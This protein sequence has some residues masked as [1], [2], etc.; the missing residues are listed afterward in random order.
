VYALELEDSREV[1]IQVT[2]QT[3]QGDVTLS[4]RHRCRE[5]ATELSCIDQ[6]GTGASESRTTVFSEGTYYIVAQAPADSTLGPYQLTVDSPFTTTCGPGSDYCV[7]RSTAAIC[8]PRGGTL[9]DM[10][11]ETGCNPTFGECFEN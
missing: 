8:G 2:P 9:N 6:G 4:V 1:T 11:C 5:L 10:S 7:D 3:S